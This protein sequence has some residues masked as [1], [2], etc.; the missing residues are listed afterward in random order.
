MQNIAFCFVTGTTRR[1]QERRTLEGTVASP[2]GF[3]SDKDGGCMFY[4]IWLA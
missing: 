4:A 3:L 2:N 1:S